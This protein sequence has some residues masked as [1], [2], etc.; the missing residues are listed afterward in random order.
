MAGIRYL[1]ARME[2]MNGKALREFSDQVR[3]RLGSGVIVLGS[4]SEGKAN[5]LAAVTRDLTDRIQAGRLIGA[6]AEKVGGRGGGRPDLAQAGG[7]RP[8]GLNEALAGVESLLV[9]LL[10]D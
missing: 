2:G 1:A 6:L 4:E 5:L 3:D 8:E 7:S 10:R 9:E